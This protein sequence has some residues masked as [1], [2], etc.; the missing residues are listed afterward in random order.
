MRIRRVRRYASVAWRQVCRRRREDAR[1]PEADPD[2]SGYC[3]PAAVAERGR[4][5]KRMR[6]P[7]AK[8]EKKREPEPRRSAAVGQGSRPAKASELPHGHRRSR[9]FVARYRD[10]QGFS[11]M[12]RG[13]LAH[14]SEART[15]VHAARSGLLGRLAKSRGRSTNERQRAK[16]AGTAASVEGVAG[17]RPLDRAG[18]D[19]RLARAPARRLAGTSARRVVGRVAPG[20]RQVPASRPWGDAG[21]P[22]LCV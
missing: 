4:A 8:E 15:A 17:G 16:T 13:S 14:V 2:P 6:G 5:E 21:G 3:S 19:L 18:A 10:L 20:A 11:W 12:S 9:I 1:R 7:G 22:R